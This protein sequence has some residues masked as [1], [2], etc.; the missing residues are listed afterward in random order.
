MQDTIAAIATAAGR[1][2]IGIV[3]VS[4]PQAADIFH[5]A[6]ASVPAP[7]TAGLRVL[8]DGAGNVIDTGIVLSFPAPHS[9][10]GEDVIEF[11]GHGGIVVLNMVLERLLAL[12]AK[13]ARP[14]EFTERAFLNGRMDLAQAE[15]VADLID[16]TSSKAARAAHASLAGEFSRRVDALGKALTALRVEVEAALD[17]PEEEIDF[18]AEDSLSG[19]FHAVL[20]AFNDTIGAASKGRRLRDAVSVVIVGAPNAGS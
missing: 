3:R 18:L 12:G 19:R 7:R 2:G 14:G 17:F 1:A 4:G 9:Y 13:R 5:T 16:A 6:C 20:D 15:A 11:Q 8:R 10:T